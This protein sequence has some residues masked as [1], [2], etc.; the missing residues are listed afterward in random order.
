MGKESLKV[1][2]LKERNMAL[3][4][5]HATLNLSYKELMAK[6]NI[7]GRGEACY[8]KMLE[9]AKEKITKLKKRSKECFGANGCKESNVTTDTTDTKQENLPE[10]DDGSEKGGFVRLRVVGQGQWQ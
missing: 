4:K 7:H 1:G 10:R 5:E 2:A 6:C 8:S 9:K 3:A